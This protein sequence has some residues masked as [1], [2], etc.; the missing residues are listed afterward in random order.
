MDK[1]GLIKFESEIKDLFL[2]KKVRFPC[3][4]SSGNE[5]ELI[6]IFKEFKEGDWVFSTHRNHYH[7]LLC[8]IKPQY[9]KEY[10]CINGSMHVY[11]RRFFTSG[12]VGGCLPIAVGVAMGIK[13]SGGKEVVWCFVGDMAASTGIFNECYR[14]SLGHKL[15]IKFIIEDNRM[16]VD[17]P[18]RHVWGGQLL[19]IEYPFA[20][21]YSYKRTFPHQG[22]GTFVEFR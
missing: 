1:E 21:Y 3:H 7:A 16:S 10:I 5:E 18:T 4:L 12:I 13:M 8:G 19:M 9:L 11:D 14:Y 2:E 20:E 22:A 17:T 15:P 6:E